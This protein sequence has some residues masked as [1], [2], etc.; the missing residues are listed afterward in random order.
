MLPSAALRSTFA[1]KVLCILVSAWPGVQSQGKGGREWTL[2]G[3]GPSV[4]V[5]VLWN[6]IH[7]DRSGEE[8]CG[9]SPWLLCLELH[10]CGPWHAWQ[11]GRWY[12]WDV[13]MSF[14]FF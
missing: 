9:M 1:H 8:P 6:S 7:R 2:S 10:G 4:H 13:S 14:A 11:A 5:I 3:E 12:G